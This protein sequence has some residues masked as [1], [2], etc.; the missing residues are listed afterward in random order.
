ML[1]G[2]AL[3]MIFYVLFDRWRSGT[4]ALGSPTPTSARV[5]TDKLDAATKEATA[6]TDSEVQQVRKLTAVELLE[7]A[8]SK[9]EKGRGR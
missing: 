1:V 4:R 8:K 2:C 5:V 7:L 3:T 9:R 6:G